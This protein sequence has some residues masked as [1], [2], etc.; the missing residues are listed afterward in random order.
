MAI[1]LVAAASAAA[2]AQA[3]RVALYCYAT[4]GHVHML[5]SKAFGMVAAAA[6]AAEL[7]LPCYTAVKQPL[8]RQ[9]C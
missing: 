3:E 7:C 1:G 4:Q 8:V 2:A 6:A 9:L 5:R